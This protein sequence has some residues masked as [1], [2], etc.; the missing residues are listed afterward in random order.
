MRSYLSLYW[1]TVS[2][3]K[4]FL[5]FLLFSRRKTF[6]QSA[7]LNSNV[8]LQVHNISLV[9]K[10]PN[11]NMNNTNT[12][13]SDGAQLQAMP[14]QASQLLKNET[15]SKLQLP[16]LRTRL[17]PTNPKVATYCSFD[18]Y[19]KLLHLELNRAFL[20]LKCNDDETNFLFF[21]S[22]LGFSYAKFVVKKSVLFFTD[23]WIFFQGSSSAGYSCNIC[24]KGYSTSS[25]L[26]KTFTHI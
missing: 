25:N 17:G 19:V 12:C 8:T 18:K 13:L 3:G 7:R 16:D 2:V 24:G 15:E 26:G 9:K 23:V 21:S 14:S 5:I 22:Y 20:S 1:F 4:I 10:E 11:N 6:Q